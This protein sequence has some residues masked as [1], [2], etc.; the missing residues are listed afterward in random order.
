MIYIRLLIPFELN[1]LIFYQVRSLLVIQSFI[2]LNN[3]LIF[4]V[5]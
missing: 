3:A 5:E 2:D 4:Q 1:V